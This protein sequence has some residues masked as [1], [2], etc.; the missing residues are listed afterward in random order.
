MKTVHMIAWISQFKTKVASMGKPAVTE[1]SF[2]LSA[3]ATTWGAGLAVEFD[4]FSAS[5]VRLKESLDRANNIAMKPP[6]SQGLLQP[7]A[8]LV[9]MP[10]ASSVRP[11]AVSRSAAQ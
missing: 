6:A 9:M 5:L 8:S 4:E 2:P 3:D 1:G 7:E 11:S 10:M